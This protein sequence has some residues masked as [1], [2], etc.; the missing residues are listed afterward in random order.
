MFIKSSI[1]LNEAAEYLQSNCLKSSRVNLERIDKLVKLS[2]SIKDLAVYQKD[3]DLLALSVF[4][5]EL[6]EQFHTWFKEKSQIYFGKGT[7]FHIPSGNI[8]LMPF[9][10]WLPSYLA[11]NPNIVRISRRLDDTYIGRL[12][13]LIDKVIGPIDGKMNIFYS[14]KYSEQLTLIASKVCKVRIVW[15]SYSTISTIRSKYPTEAV[16]DL[17]FPT[18]HSVSIID[19]GNYSELDNTGRNLL[20]R[21][22]IDDTIQF[23]FKACS[24]PHYTY[25]LGR[26]S[27]KY[28]LVLDFL[29]RI[30]GM[31]ARSE[32][33]MGVM[34]TNNFLDNQ[35]NLLQRT[36]CKPIQ[37]IAGKS[38]Y[39]ISSKEVPSISKEQMDCH[40]YF[41]NADYEEEIVNTWPSDIQTLSLINPMDYDFAVKISNKLGSKTPDRIIPIGHALKF[42]LLW[43]G[44]HFLE[45]LTRQVFI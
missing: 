32:T 27:E 42:S 11:G 33:E 37:L 43:D 21:R 12:V 16:I 35:S 24:S 17:C 8:P 15:G 22:Y 4:S 29:E 13:D 30:S 39:Y 14:S 7:T 20:C 1:D 5:F 36:K 44:Q 18:R 10:S 28:L 25:W 9:Y 19:V 2:N 6:V 38:I 26:K 23:T 40:V 34:S 45:T 31:I 41:I 3:S